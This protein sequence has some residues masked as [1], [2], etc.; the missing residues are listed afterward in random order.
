MYHRRRFLQLEFRLFGANAMLYLVAILCP[1]LAL[2]FSGQWGSMIV[3]LVM[4]ICCV[5]FMFVGVGFLLYLLPI[6]HACVC[7]S[8]KDADRRDERLMKAM[9]A[10]QAAANRK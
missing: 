9:A 10:G 4:A 2:L 8:R 7:L 3:N 6:A 5:P 1:P